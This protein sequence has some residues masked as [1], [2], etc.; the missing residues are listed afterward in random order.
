M[1]MDINHRAKITKDRTGIFSSLPEF[2][3]SVE[4]GKTI[5]EW[6]N[7]EAKVVQLNFSKDNQLTLA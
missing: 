4:T 1:E 7:G 2:V 6:C 3:P 5:L